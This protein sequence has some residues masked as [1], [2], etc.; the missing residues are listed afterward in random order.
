MAAAAAPD[1]SCGLD[2]SPP[3]RGGRLTP[4]PLLDARWGTGSGTAADVCAHS[5]LCCSP[6]ARPGPARLGLRGPGLITFAIKAVATG[7]VKYA[8]A[9]SFAVAAGEMRRPGWNRPSAADLGGHWEEGDIHHSDT[10]IL[11]GEEG[12]VCVRVCVEYYVFT[13]RSVSFCMRIFHCFI[14]NFLCM[15]GNCFT[16]I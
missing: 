7:T 9:V 2:R 12:W 16:V 3:P 5:A 6:L 15:V 13:V 1:W 14:R 11:W 10:R 4:R 8:W